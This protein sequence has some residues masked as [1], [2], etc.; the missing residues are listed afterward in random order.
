MYIPRNVG[1]LTP[2]WLSRVLGLDH[3]AAIRIERIGEQFGFAGK[4][5]R[6]SHQG[7]S[8]VIKLWEGD[9]QELRFYREVAPKTPVRTPRLI[10]A[11]FDPSSRSGILILEDLW[12]LVKGDC[13]VD[14]DDAQVAAVARSLAS[15]HRAWWDAPELRGL[16]RGSEVMKPDGWFESRKQ[17]ALAKIPAHLGVLKHVV[18]NGPQVQR[19]ASE[20]LQAGCQTLLHR[21][22]HQD[23]LLFDEEGEPVI[24]DWARWSPGSYALNIA[25]LMMMS[26]PLRA[27]LAAEHYY[28]AFAPEAR[29]LFDAK[30]RG[31]LLWRAI[32]AT[33]GVANW[34][35]PNE[36]A[37]AIIVRDME[38]I[39]AMVAGSL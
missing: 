7:G 11:D 35:S 33:F 12:H 29:E 26:G 1:D 31:A 17:G 28:L 21:D 25:D 23:N 10:F 6:C 19:R 38:T 5:Y 24:L 2:A 3:E 27:Q 34:N 39:N 4:L 8:V 37:R 13:L 9:D 20:L 14:L 30:V 18:E 16:D 22:L 32:I 15:M 36:R